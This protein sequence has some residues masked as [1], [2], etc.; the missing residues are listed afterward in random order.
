MPAT[1]TLWNTIKKSKGMGEKLLCKQNT[2]HQAL[3]LESGHLTCRKTLELSLQGYFCSHL[4]PGTNKFT[5]SAF[6]SHWKLL[7]ADTLTETRWCRGQQSE[8]E[9][10]ITTTSRHN[11][12][13][14]GH[15]TQEQTAPPTPEAWKLSLRFG[16]LHNQISDGWPWL[17]HELG[18]TFWWI[19]YSLKVYFSTE[20]AKIETW[21]T[22]YLESLSKS[23]KHF[24]L[25]KIITTGFQFNPWESLRPLNKKYVWWIKSI[26]WGSK[27]KIS[28]YYTIASCKASEYI[29]KLPTY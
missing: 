10:G 5:L 21:K 28:L 29:N 23:H 3:G 22:K 13:N 20:D 24:Y 6:Q 11:N 19:V 25:T 26:T 9:N 2:S 17:I 16:P 18:I 15:L 12:K 14:L 7:K 4:K 8:K 1:S 27:T